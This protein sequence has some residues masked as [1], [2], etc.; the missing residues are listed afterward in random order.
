MF[1][2]VP[3][4]EDQYDGMITLK[5]QSKA[6]GYFKLYIWNAKITAVKGTVLF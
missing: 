6:I 4:R 5:I 1:P 3:D 2:T